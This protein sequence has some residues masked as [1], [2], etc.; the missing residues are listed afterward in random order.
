MAE[1][2]ANLPHMCRV[3]VKPV[4]RRVTVPG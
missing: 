1:A 2:S 4:T 3:E